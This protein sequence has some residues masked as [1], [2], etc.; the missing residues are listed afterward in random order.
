MN[1][2]WLGGGLHAV[3][4]TTILFLCLHPLRDALEPAVLDLVKTTSAWEA[5]TGLAL[6]ILAGRSG[7]RK[8]AALLFTGAAMSSGMIYFLS[9][10]G[11][12]PFDPLVP[13]GGLVTLIGWIALIVTGAKSRA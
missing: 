7:F 2:K 3:L 4:G 9:F 1:W 8:A 12:H 6:L 11:H 10:T 5:L 13:M